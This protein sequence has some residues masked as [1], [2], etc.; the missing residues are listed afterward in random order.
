MSI[1]SGE[2]YPLDFL[3][4]FKVSPSQAWDT[5]GNP[6]YNNE[7]SIVF[8]PNEIDVII[9]RPQLIDKKYL[10]IKYE[11]YR[12][13]SF[14]YD[15]RLIKT[16]KPIEFVMKNNKFIV[17]S[18][19]L[20]KADSEQFGEAILSDWGYMGSN[21]TVNTNKEPLQKDTVSIH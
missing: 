18:I 12:N 14:S 13:S 15:I 1:K 17:N 5:L 8:L 6:A 4:N 7:P 10:V 11:K 9:S 21:K 19:C 20:P 2:F 16:V 3:E